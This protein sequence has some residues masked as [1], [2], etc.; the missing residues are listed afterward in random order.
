MNL[1]KVTLGLTTGATYNMTN[2]HVFKAAQARRAYFFAGGTYKDN[3]F[4][5]FF[6]RIAFFGMLPQKTA[7]SLMKVLCTRNFLCLHQSSKSNTNLIACKNVFVIFTQRGYLVH[8]ADNYSCLR[9]ETCRTSLKW[10]IIQ[11]YVTPVQENEFDE[12]TYVA[13]IWTTWLY[14][15]HLQLFTIPNSTLGQFLIL[16]SLQRWLFV[17]DVIKEGR[18]EY[19]QFL[20]WQFKEQ[21][22][23]VYKKG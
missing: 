23:A 21:I 20:L 16:L 14:L 17:S 1:Y 19:S 6:N 22:F 2:V 8:I 12:K 3:I 15:L 7:Y 5:F 11:V 4:L 13:K 10:L 18:I 9:K